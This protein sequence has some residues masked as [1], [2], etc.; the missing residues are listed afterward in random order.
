MQQLGDEAMTEEKNVKSLEKALDIRRRV[1]SEEHPDIASSYNNVGISYEK[2]GDL[3]RG[4][5]YQEK[6]LHIR[7]RVLGE[8]HPNTAASYGNVGYSYT[9][10]WNRHEEAAEYFHRAYLISRKHSGEENPTTKK[11]FTRWKECEKKASE[12]HE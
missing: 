1:L 8:E 2:M 7:R 3:E 10:F 4:L 9:N 6:A 5:Q 12:S 11:Y